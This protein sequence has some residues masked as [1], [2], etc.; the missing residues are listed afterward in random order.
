[1]DTFCSE[2]FTMETKDWLIFVTVLRFSISSGPLN[3]SL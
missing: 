3:A 2:E 1:M